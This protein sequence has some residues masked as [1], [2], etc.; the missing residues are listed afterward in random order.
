VLVACAAANEPTASEVI[1][2]LGLAAMVATAG[3]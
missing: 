2:E 1:R 3:S